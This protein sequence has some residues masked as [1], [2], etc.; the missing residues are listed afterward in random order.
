MISVC[1]LM[2]SIVVLQIWDLYPNFYPVLLSITAVP[3]RTR[4]ANIPDNP[5]C[6]V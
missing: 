3:L 1:D 2:L 5:W 4:K 6:S